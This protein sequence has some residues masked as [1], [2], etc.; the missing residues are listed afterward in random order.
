MG[1]EPLRW[2]NACGLSRYSVSHERL[3]A[4]SPSS[5]REKP[6]RSRNT[7]R[8][9]SDS[10]AERNTCHCCEPVRTYCP[11]DRSASTRRLSAAT[12]SGAYLISSIISG[13]GKFERN[14][15]GSL[16][17]L[18]ISIAGSSVTTSQLWS[19]CRTSVLFPI[20]RAPETTTIGKFFVSFSRR[21]P[22]ARSRYRIVR[23]I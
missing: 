3:P 10:R 12:S 1:R 7:A 23:E 9:A 15:S 20:W 11:G 2:T 21:A 5:W 19:M 6:S 16:L 13:G 8:P 4:L 17:A 18:A 22:S 14:R